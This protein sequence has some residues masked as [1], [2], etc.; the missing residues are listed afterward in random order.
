MKSVSPAYFFLFLN[1]SFNLFSFAVSED[2]PVLVKPLDCKCSKPFCDI[3]SVS[4]PGPGACKCL[5]C[6]TPELG[7]KCYN[8][9]FDGHPTCG[10]VFTCCNGICQRGPCNECHEPCGVPYCTPESIYVYGPKPCRCI[11]C[12]EP[13]PGGKCYETFDGTPTCGEELTNL[14]CSNGICR[15]SN[16]AEI[17]NCPPARC[18]PGGVI[19]AGPVPCNCQTCVIPEP[20]VKC[21][22]PYN[23][24]QTCGTNFA[25]CKGICQEKSKPCEKPCSCPKLSCD[26]SSISIPGPG[27]C[28][29]PICVTPASGD[30]CYK[31]SLDDQPICGNVLTCCNGTCQT[32]PCTKKCKCPPIPC[33]EGILVPGQEPCKCPTCVIPE[34]GDKCFES[35][36]GALTCGTNLLCCEGLCQEI[37]K[38]CNGP[39]QCPKPFCDPEDSIFIPG[40]GPCKCPI[41]VK[42]E[43]GD[44]CYYESFTS[45]ITCGNRLTCCN[46]IC[47]DGSCDR[48]DQCGHLYCTSKSIKVFGPRPCRCPYC[49]E[50]V[51]GGPCFES[52]EGNPTCG[53]DYPNPT[54]L[55]CCNGVCVDTFTNPCRESC[56]CHQVNCYGKAVI[57]SGPEPC[58]CPKCVL[59]EP[60]NNCLETL[61]VDFICG[62]DM[63]CCDGWCQKNGTC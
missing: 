52:L 41:C 46:G 63:V 47:Q 9:S 37:S 6:V 36:N 13:E 24:T 35:R 43:P 10:N 55:T 45:I 33:T 54:N 4:T 53:E 2:A 14:T 25:C 56:Y 28:K 17:C 51:R 23:G 29:C 20:G 30:A 50:P 19:V 15:P 48:C 38:P 40:P 61:E 12:V 31:S 44:K 42:P 32:K 58:K 22:K 16:L 39:C 62:S 57:V 49:I 11:S 1:I 7:G 26:V 3:F 27:P 18:P 21:L 5:V 59:P 34:P 8:S 60:G